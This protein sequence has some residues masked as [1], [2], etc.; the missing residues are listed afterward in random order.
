VSAPFVVRSVSRIR[1]GKA[2][3]YRP[4]AAQLCRLAEGREPRLLAFRIYVGEDRSSEVVLQDYP[5]HRGGFTRPGGSAS[6]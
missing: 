1:P 4:I 3:E 2:E 6:P 5:V